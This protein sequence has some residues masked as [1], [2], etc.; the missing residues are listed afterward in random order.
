MG[1]HFFDE[2]VREAMT[3]VSA[4]VFRLDGAAPGRQSFVDALRPDG[5]PVQTTDYCTCTFVQSV[6]G[7]IQ[8]LV[9]VAELTLGG[10]NT[11]TVD[12]SLIDMSTQG[13]SI[14]AFDTNAQGECFLTRSAGDDIAGVDRRTGVLINKEIFRRNIVVPTMNDPANGFASE[15]VIADNEAVI[16][17]G[18]DVLNDGLGGAFI[19]RNT[20]SNTAAAAPD[21]FSNPN[22]TGGFIE[23]VGL[24]TTRTR[25]NILVV[26]GGVTTLL[27]NAALDA[28][29]WRFEASNDQDNG[30]ILGGQIFGGATPMVQ[31]I[32]R[33]GELFFDV[34]GAAVRIRNT[35]AIDK[36]ITFS[37]ERR[38]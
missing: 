24:K 9:A 11:L 29:S 18:V 21:V 35:S 12:Q 38:A 5:T 20:S 13:G 8:S 32:S 2:R 27:S 15:G 36:R 37:E 30:E 3:P 14:P 7:S 16:A 23:R 28:A 31:D 1:V 34:E 19:Q 22:S 33:T 17:L 6:A 26:A 25:G 10:V 4:G